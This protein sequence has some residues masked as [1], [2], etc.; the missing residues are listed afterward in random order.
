MAVIQKEK[1]PNIKTR[2]LY[3]RRKKKVHSDLLDTEMLKKLK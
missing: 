2:H 3:L 1:T